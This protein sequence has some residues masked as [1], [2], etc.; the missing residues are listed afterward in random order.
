MGRKEVE[1]LIREMSERRQERLK[2][3]KN[4]ELNLKYRKIHMEKG[5]KKAEIE[6]W[7]DWLKEHKKNNKKYYGS[8]V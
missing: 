7:K 5:P 2:R 8:S 4:V 6:E 1:D 3:K